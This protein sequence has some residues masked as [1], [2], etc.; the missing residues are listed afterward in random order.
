MIISLCFAFIAIVT[1]FLGIIG[2]AVG[3]QFRY[4]NKHARKT[5]DQVD[6]KLNK[7]TKNGR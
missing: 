4:I 3:R 1:L 2:L 5:I 7:T 6:K